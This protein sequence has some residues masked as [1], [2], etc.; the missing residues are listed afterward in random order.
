MLPVSTFLQRQQQNFFLHCSIFNVINHYC[1]DRCFFSLCQHCRISSVLIMTRVVHLRADKSQIPLREGDTHPP[2]FC[3]HT[4]PRSLLLPPLVINH[5]SLI[6][7][8]S[9]NTSHFL[10]PPSLLLS[11]PT[12]PCLPLSH[13]LRRS[14]S[15]ISSHISDHAS[16]ILT[17]SKPLLLFTPAISFLFSL[18]LIDSKPNQSFPLH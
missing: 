14:L 1:I 17:R 9:A 16:W 4:S 7:P 10:S 3:P 15:L 6:H 5:L 11:L 2:V 8:R 12:P 18:A 13:M